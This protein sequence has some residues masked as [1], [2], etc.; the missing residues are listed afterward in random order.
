MITI[1]DHVVWNQCKKE[2]G[3]A[4]EEAVCGGPLFTH[5]CGE[6]MVYKTGTVFQQS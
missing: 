3:S 5:G 6:V 4:Q 1:I 2:A